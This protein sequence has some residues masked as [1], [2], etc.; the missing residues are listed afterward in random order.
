MKTNTKPPIIHTHEG[1][2]AKQISAKL[3]LRRSVMACMLWEGEFYEDGQEIAKR[4]GYA[5][6]HTPPLAVAGIAMEARSTMKLRH[7]PLLI[8]SHMAALPEHKKL[9]A[10]TLFNVIQRPD[11]LAEFLA[12]HAKL[13]PGKPLKKMVSAQIKRGLAA[14][15]T[16]FDGYALAKYNRD[17][18]IKLRDVLFLCHAKA[19]DDAQAAVFKQLVDGTLPTPDTW[20]VSLSAGADKKTTWERL[21][22]EQKLGALALLRNL[23]NMQQAGVGDDVIRAAIVLMKT[24]RVLPFRFIAAARHAA[25]FEPELEEAM[26]NCLIERPKL[27]GDTILM[28]D[29]SGSMD[30]PISAKSDLARVD[31]AC[32]L[33]MLLREVCTH[34]QVFTFSNDIMAVPPRRGFA[35]RD[36]VVTSQHHSGTYLGRAVQAVIDR[37]KKPDRLIVI[38]DE[39][40]ADAVP[41]PNLKRAYMLNVASARNGVG[42]GPWQHIDGWSE[43]VVDYIQALEAE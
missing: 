15:F 7:V 1:A 35:L 19:K 10:A 39:Q 9:V 31:A 30:V 20:E 11:E 24:E 8:V 5:V 25:Q 34:V 27:T 43:A 16:K 18:A 14:A 3:T 17:G 22:V 38:S 21:L 36:A 29:V 6:E 41:D 12:I 28:V 26:F 32:G 42:Y 23:R 40:A 2:P 4:I 13:N 37:N 33:A